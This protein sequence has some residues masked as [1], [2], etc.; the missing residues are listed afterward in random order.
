LAG[1]LMVLES[2]LAIPWGGEGAESP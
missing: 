1:G 2:I